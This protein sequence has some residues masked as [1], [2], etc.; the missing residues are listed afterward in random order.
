MISVRL[1][2]VSST[3]RFVC[4]PSRCPDVAA[5]PLGR[6]GNYVVAIR[7]HAFEGFASIGYAV[8]VCELTRVWRFHAILTRRLL[9]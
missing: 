8:V 2:H 1:E 6:R 4:S 9:L 5:V 3:S 7:A